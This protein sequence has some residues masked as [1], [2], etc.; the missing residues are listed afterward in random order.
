MEPPSAVETLGAVTTPTI[1]KVVE[2]PA[3]VASPAAPSAASKD[4]IAAA[5]PPAALTFAPGASPAIQ[6]RVSPLAAWASF[7]ATEAKREAD[8]A[9]LLAAKPRPDVERELQL[10][11]FNE[12]WR[13]VKMGGNG[14][15]RAVV[16]AS[17]SQ[18]GTERLV[19]SP[20]AAKESSNE[21]TSRGS[22]STPAPSRSQSVGTEQTIAPQVRHARPAVNLSPPRPKPTGESKGKSMAQCKSGNVPTL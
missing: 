2:S 16:G 5:K 20:A 12:T 6:P 13:Q 22:S 9:A 14:G 11:T 10:P 18:V 21:P 8:E 17:K 19:P 1:T 4:Q 15:N 7:G 3:S